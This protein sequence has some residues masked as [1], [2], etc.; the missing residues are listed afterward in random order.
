MS[1]FPD[2][3]SL[4]QAQSPPVVAA[5]AVAAAV[6]VIQAQRGDPQSSFTLADLAGAIGAITM[7]DAAR[8]WLLS[9]S[10]AAWQAMRTLA[11]RQVKCELT[12]PMCRIAITHAIY[13]ASPRLSEKTQLFSS[14]LVYH[15]ISILFTDPRQLH[16][17]GAFSFE[18][19][20]AVAFENDPGTIQ[21]LIY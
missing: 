13:P 3:T 9:T 6:R 7:N 15:R 1:W 5:A 10:R 16:I 17:S 4:S 18:S 20:A 8:D 12:E 14:A 2:H 11:W 19:G 21:E